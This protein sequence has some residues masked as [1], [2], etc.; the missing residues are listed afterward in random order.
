LELFA[1]T[2]AHQTNLGRLS[3]IENAVIKNKLYII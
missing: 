2:L 3:I 1:N